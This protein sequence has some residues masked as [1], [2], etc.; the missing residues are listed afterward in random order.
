[1]TMPVSLDAASEAMRDAMRETVR[2]HS[3]WYLLQ[4]ALMILAGFIALV[5]PAMSSV[6]LVIFLGWLFIIS[7]LVQ[8]I[9]LI[10]ARAAPHFLAATRIR[11]PVHDRGSAFS[12]Q[13]WRKHAHA[14]AARDRVLHGRGHCESDFGA[15]DT[16]AS[17]L[18]LAL[19][20]RHPGDRVG[21]L[22]V[23]QPTRG[24]DLAARCTAGD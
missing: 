18:E 22:P 10:G 6:A 5:H 3:H 14:L 4:S 9:G 17:I 15:D 24:G 19:A 8:G 12:A 16:P 23:G 7:G 11:R 20:Q 2:R 13:S 21:V 1:M